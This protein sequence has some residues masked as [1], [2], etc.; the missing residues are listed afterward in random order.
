M[1]IASFEGNSERQRY[2]RFHIS[3]TSRDDTTDPARAAIDA[4]DAVRKRWGLFI[5][6]STRSRHSFRFRL[7]AGGEGTLSHRSRMWRRIDDDPNP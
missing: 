7:R 1:R 3:L 6:K 2:A 5:D 4:T